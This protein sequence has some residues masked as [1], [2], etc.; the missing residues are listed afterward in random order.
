MLARDLLDVR[1]ESGSELVA[2]VIDLA[3]KARVDPE[4]S[5][6]DDPSVVPAAVQ[7]EAAVLPRAEADQLSA[8][9]GKCE[10]G[11][12]TWRAVSLPVLRSYEVADIAL[13]L[14]I[15]AL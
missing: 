4:P 12:L 11:L 2:V 5:E 14:L 3:L 8:L 13:P 9:D 6:V 1:V 7:Y 10:M 15:A